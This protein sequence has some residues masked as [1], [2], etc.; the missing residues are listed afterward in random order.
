MDSPVED[1]VA[2]DLEFHKKIAVGSG[3]SVLA[4][5]VD[6]MS[7]PT[8]RARIWRGMTEP[9]ALERTLAEHRA[10][11]QAIVIRRR[12]PRPVLGD[13]PHRAAS[14]P[15]CAPRSLT[16]PVCDDR[17]VTD[18][19]GRPPPSAPTPGEAGLVTGPERESSSVGWP[20]HHGFVQSAGSGP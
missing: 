17:P 15:G 18:G 14:S 2:A 16:D 1:F 8:A 4:S 10:I 7:L 19:A 3:N 5:L 9:R 12:R 20:W 11:Y 13:G 6:N